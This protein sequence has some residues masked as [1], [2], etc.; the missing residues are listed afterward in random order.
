MAASTQLV[1]GLS[2]G[3]DWRSMIDQLMAIEHRGVDLLEGK[4]S[5][6]AA[7]LSEWR[8]FNTNLLSLKTASEG[9]KDPEDFYLYTSNMSTDD[10]SVK[11][12]DLLSVTTSSSASKGSYA[13]IIDALASAQK[14][15]SKSFS[16]YSE[17]LG[18]SYTGDILI[19]GKTASV[20]ATDSLADVR[21]KINNTNAGTNPTGVGAAIVTYAANDYRLILTSDST[22]TGGISLQNGSS[23]DLVELFGWKDKSSSLKNSMTGGAQ[24]DSFTS[25]TQDIQTLLDLST[26]QSGTIRIKDGN[27]L[28][29]DVDIDLSARSLEDIKTAINDASI[30]GVSASIVLEVTGGKTKYRLQI[31]G[32]QDFVDSQNIL[33]TLGILQNGTAAVQGTTSGNTITENG[34]YIGAGTFLV[35]IDGY[36]QFTTGDKISLGA[37]SRDHS[38]NDVSGD[39]LT[40]TENTTVQD[41]LDALETAYEANGDQV[42][43]YLTSQGKIEVSDQED[44]DSSLLVDLQSTIGDSYSSL[45]WGTFTSLDEVRERQLVAGAD[46]SL[47]IDGVAL[48]SQDNSVDGVLPGVT[49][50]LRKADPGTAITLN[51]NRDIDAIM[52]KIESFLDAYNT[53]ASYIK[54]QQS[55][56]QEKGEPGGKLFGDGTLSSVKSDLTSTLIQQIGGVSS[57]LSTLGLAGIN[58]DNEGQIRMD[59][60]RLKGYLETHFNDIR[61]LFSSNGTSDS[62]NLE[63]VSHSRDAKAGTYAVNITQAARQSTTTSDAA[64]NGSLG[65]DET[66]TIKEGTRTA[67]ISLKSGMTVSDIIN[68]VNTELDAVYTERLVGSEVLT[69]GLDPITSATT[70]ESI[71]EANLEDGDLISF[72]GTTR[73]GQTVSG[74]YEIGEASTDTVQGLLSAMALA[75]GKEIDATMDTSGRLVITD[76]HQGDSQLSISFDYAQAHD[77]DFGTVSATTSG[78]Q[79]GRYAMGITASSDG[80]NH[81]ALRHNNYGSSFSFTVEEDTDAGLWTGSQTTP[82]DVDNGLDVA[83]TVNGEAATGSGQLLVGNDGEGNIDGLSIKYSGSSTGNV[84]NITLTLGIAELFERALYSIT[85]PYAGYVTFKQTSLQNSISGFETQIEQM[86]TRLDKKMEMMINRFVLMELA[87]SRIQSQSNWLSGQLDASLNGW[88]SR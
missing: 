15:S 22:G 3:F 65:A 17:A 88:G 13:I 27:A 31:D 71:D 36:N 87:L 43:V 53:V 47:R 62:G 21:N 83:G 67:T 84:G 10:S 38:G 4:K 7:K 14:L 30:A 60:D 37:A 44:G 40:I 6:Y 20:T 46:A 64:V 70:W 54:E 72:T 12:A 25:L 68:A 81:L 33:E 11:A 29:Q 77:L 78:G 9:L 1:S 85:D 66:L 23:S 48:T 39:I 59:K 63:Y 56:D 26:A 61:L 76:K 86:E 75:F 45:N 52:G 57:E 74:S 41:L 34:Q 16:S 82:V 42:S 79:E 50:N 58:L 18:A 24:S 80:S 19:N 8:A 5:Q 73:N 2:S 28:Y 69:A 49:L 35:D 51:I 32:S 55:Y